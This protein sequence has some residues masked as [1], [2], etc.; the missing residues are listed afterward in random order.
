MAP[1]E[2]GN[3]KIRL[4]RRAQSQGQLWER[5]GANN[6]FS[7]F[8]CTNYKHTHNRHSAHTQLFV[9][10]TSSAMAFSRRLTKTAITKSK[11]KPKI[12]NRQILI[13]QIT[14]PPVLQN[15]WIILKF[16]F[17]GKETM[18]GL[19]WHLQNFKGLK[20]INLTQLNRGLCVLIIQ[21]KRPSLQLMSSFLRC[22]QCVC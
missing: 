15:I 19:E 18:N 14:D 16:H 11:Y 2:A 20:V 4:Q 22:Q 6:Y 8:L 3:E 5:W 17:I 13:L 1:F 12:W 21:E 10:R 7:P 9:T